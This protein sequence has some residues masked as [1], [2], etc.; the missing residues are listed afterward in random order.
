MHVLIVECATERNDE[1]VS[2]LWE[3]GTT[4]IV[5]RELSHERVELQAF[6]R[7]KFPVD[8]DLFPAARWEPVEDVNWVRITMESWDPILVGDRFFVVPDWRNDPT[9][10]GRL[11]LEVHPGL[12]LG[13]GY[14]P[15]TQMCL[16][17]MERRL[18]PGSSFLDLGAGSGILSQAAVLLG[19]DRIVACDVDPQA[20]ESAVENFQR[21]GVSALLFTGSVTAVKTASTDFLV[22]NISAPTVLDL[23]DDIARVLVAEGLAVLSGFE[24]YRIAD[25]VD[26]IRSH[27]FEVLDEMA[28][29]DWAAITARRI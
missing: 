28:R 7:E 19:A 20:I 26:G 12:A 2:E 10:P 3:R 24:P 29:D 5:E 9:P 14:H 15:T 8:P 13:T 1:F 27:G 4:G 21:A 25:V 17:V 23:A 16:E 11:R 18:Q 22:A 6:F